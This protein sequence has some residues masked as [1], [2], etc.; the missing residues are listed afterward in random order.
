MRILFLKKAYSPVGGSEVL[1]YQLATRL[2][3]RGHEVQVV[4]QWP[5]GERYGF[6]P[7][8][9]LVETDLDYRR[10]VHEGVEV[11]QLRP[12]LGELGRRLDVLAPF[13]MLRYDLAR[14]LVDGADI[15]HNICREYAPQAVRLA[16][17]LGAA[18]VMT[19][20]A[21]A[22]QFL[23]GNTGTD[24]GRYQQ[25][26]A[27]VA[28]TEAERGWY[29]EQG[30]AANKVAVIGLGPNLIC[31]GDAKW[32]RRRFRVPGPIV[33]Y[34]GRK[35]RYKGVNVLAEAAPLVWRQFPETRFVFIGEASLFDF[36]TSPFRG[37][38]EP[39]LINL[40]PVDEPTKAAAYAACDVF[41]MPSRHETFGLVYAEAWLC[42][43]PVVGGDIPNLRDVI[44][45][46]KDGFLV[47]Q[48]P[49]EV[50]GALIHLLA[51]PAL[52]CRLGA[53]GRRKVKRLYNWDVVVEQTESLY[54]R[55]IKAE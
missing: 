43:K 1:T 18:L 31:P 49:D 11:F 13:N 28:L 46:G 4:C 29:A 42:G 20:L 23:A 7:P 22:G 26:D 55:L 14:R 17:E 12:N 30:V 47:G 48:R 24:I 53:A 37:R 50:A 3:S 45:H 2:A 40:P 39:R 6:P 51:D 10:F 9:S 32:F 19:P 16:R 5:T 15:V 25:A 44:E 33:L 35:E 54:A 36:I 34:V 21:H 38:I 52:R 27:L 8:Q 41:C